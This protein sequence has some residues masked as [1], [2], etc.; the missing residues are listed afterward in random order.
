VGAGGGA[1]GGRGRAAGAQCTPCRGGRRA[2]ECSCQAGVAS[3]ARR[4]EVSS[5]AVDEAELPPA[6]AIYLHEGHG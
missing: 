6:I 1:G 5:S 3:E 2:G 4:L